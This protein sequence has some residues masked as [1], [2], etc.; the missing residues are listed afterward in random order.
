LFSFV[1]LPQEFEKK[2]KFS[3]AV[4][5]LDV[6]KRFVWTNNFKESVSE[7]LHFIENEVLDYNI[8][9]NNIQTKITDF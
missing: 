6:L 7:N 9:K 3:K 2:V 1:P 4:E 5:A 8:F